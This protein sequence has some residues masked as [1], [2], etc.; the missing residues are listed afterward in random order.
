MQTIEAEQI[1]EQGE[2]VVRETK[3]ERSA[4]GVERRVVGWRRGW[5][6]QEQRIVGA[7]LVEGW[8]T[9]TSSE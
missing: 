3:E 8:L 5:I 7:E 1:L 4:S 9:G 6:R 2:R